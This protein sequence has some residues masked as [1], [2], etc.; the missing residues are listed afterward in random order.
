VALAMFVNE[1]Q[2]TPS[3][4]AWGVLGCFELRRLFPGLDNTKHG[5]E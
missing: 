5:R 3:S 2:A 4:P 1:A